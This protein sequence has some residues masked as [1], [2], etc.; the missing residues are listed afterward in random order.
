M[1]ARREKPVLQRKKKKDSN[2]LYGYSM[3]MIHKAALR[4]RDATLRAN[5]NTPLMLSV[6]ARAAESKHA[7]KD[8]LHREFV[9]DRHGGFGKGVLPPTSDSLWTPVL[10]QLALT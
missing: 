5:G 7:G 3:R 4:L 8:S 9:L 6:A 10:F 1:R 2:R